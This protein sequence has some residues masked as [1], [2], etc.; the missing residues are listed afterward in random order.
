MK[1]SPHV[2]NECIFTDPSNAV[3]VLEPMS[4]VKVTRD[5]QDLRKMLSRSRRNSLSNFDSLS[6]E[7]PAEEP[8]ARARPAFQRRASLQHMGESTR[9][10][11]ARTTS[12]SKLFVAKPKYGK[13]EDDEE[14]EVHLMKKGKRDPLS[15]STSHKKDALSKSSRHIRESLSR[16]SRHLRETLSR[17]RH[18]QSGRRSKFSSTRGNLG[19]S[20]DYDDM[21]S[22]NSMDM[23]QSMNSFS[24]GGCE[25]EA[26]VLIDVLDK[27]IEILNDRKNDLQEQVQTNLDLAT[28]RFVGGSKGTCALVAMRSA[29]KKK[30]LKAFTVAARFQLIALRKQL[31]KELDQARSQPWD[32]QEVAQLETDLSEVER[33]MEE[34]LIELNSAVCPTPNDEALLRQLHALVEQTPGNKMNNDEGIC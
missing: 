24:E 27:H 32:G 1:Q 34:T 4:P 33:S 28:A 2:T 23:T 17:S 20:S 7:Q 29:T 10:L 18:G 12:V 11:L 30:A 26:M 8:K 15:K 6:D 19:G 16:S 22:E 3:E 21:A 25:Y 9:R 31:Q 13:Y 14:N 5:S